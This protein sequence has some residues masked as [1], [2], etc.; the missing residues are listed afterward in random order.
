VLNVIGEESDRETRES[1]QPHDWAPLMHTLKVVGC[2]VVGLLL[3]ACDSQA[4]TDSAAAGSTP[5]AGFILA[6]GA[7]T[8][9]AAVMQKWSR[10]CALCHVTGNAG[11]PRVGNVGE[12]QERL[13]QGAGVLLTHTI[14][15]FNDMP[16]LGYCMSC[17]REDFI[18]MIDFMAGDSTGDTP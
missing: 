3:V 15:G 4:P 18:A 2:L 16:P 14:E 5:V 11:A 7:D 9:N 10:S 12:W 6:A 1:A 13:T 8:L 17:E